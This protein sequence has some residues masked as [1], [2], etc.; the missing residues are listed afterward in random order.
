MIMFNV[1]NDAAP[2]MPIAS[3]VQ[4]NTDKTTW[5]K[6]LRD[7]LAF[8]KL[9]I[10]VAISQRVD[11]PHSPTSVNVGTTMLKGKACCVFVRGMKSGLIE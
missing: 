8:R 4:W 5:K 7:G 3:S 1:V 9:Q 11:L 10:M 6:Q 2:D